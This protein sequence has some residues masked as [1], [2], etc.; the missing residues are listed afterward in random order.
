[1]SIIHSGNKKDEMKFSY[2]ID[3]VWNT[4]L[5][6]IKNIEFMKISKIDP[7]RKYLEVRTGFGLWTY[8]ENVTIVA[9]P[10]N[11]RTSIVRVSSKYRFTQLGDFVDKHRKN[12]EKVFSEL[13]RILTAPTILEQKVLEY[14]KT[15]ESKIRVSD[16]AK[17]IDVTVKE[18]DN[19]IKSLE[20]KGLL[21][22]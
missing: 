3:V 5:C 19:A 6:A 4:L 8:G 17:V 10:I 16:C 1:M 22:R 11:E 9:I 20:E 2:P 13:T 7:I 14:V 18:V 15:H 21:K 12:I